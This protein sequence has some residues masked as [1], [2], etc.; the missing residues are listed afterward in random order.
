MSN[1]SEVSEVLAETAYRGKTLLDWADELKVMLPPVPA[2]NQQ[3]QQAITDL[4][5][6]YQISYNCY[7]EVMAMY[8][9]A[10]SQYE[11]ARDAA[12]SA[13]RRELLDGNIK[14]P[15]KEIL[16]NIAVDSS[17]AAR[18]KRDQMTGIELIQD[19]FEHKKIMLEKAMQLVLGLNY[20]VNASDKMNHRH[21]DPKL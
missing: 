12:I 4:N 10:K 3:I 13:K 16:E 14:I 19:F 11:A 1:E 15:A 6:K 17:P 7:I 8:S 2:T 21:G 20:A 5:N 9:R 18:A